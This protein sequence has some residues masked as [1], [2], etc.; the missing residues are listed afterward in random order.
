MPNIL[1]V[2]DSDIW[3]RLTKDVLKKNSYRLLEADSGEQALEVVRETP[4]DLVI[5]DYRMNR[6]DG[7]DTSRRLRE[8]PGCEQVPVILITSEKFPGDC[9]ET[10]APYVDGYVDKKHLIH[11]LDDCV[12]HHLDRSAAVA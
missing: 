4:V 10:P 6:L 8:I 9:K 11:E 3:R 12:K 1:I 7:V 2:D 5:M